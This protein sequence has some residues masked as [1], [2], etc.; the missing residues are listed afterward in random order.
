MATKK[1]E[2]PH[3][4]IYSVQIIVGNVGELWEVVTYK[5]LILCGRS[6]DELVLSCLKEGKGYLW[7]QDDRGQR[8]EVILHQNLHSFSITK[9]PSRN[10]LLIF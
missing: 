4:T 2:T 9:D 8:C 6:V 3:N 5:G 10:N 7:A 1:R